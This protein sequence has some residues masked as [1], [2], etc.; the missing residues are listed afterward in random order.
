MSF[1]GRLTSIAKNTLYNLTKINPVLATTPSINGIGLSRFVSN[2]TYD[3]LEAIH[4]KGP[5]IKNR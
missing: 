3:V 2:V 1:L 5:L 4:L